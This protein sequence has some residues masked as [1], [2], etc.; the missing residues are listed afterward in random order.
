[1]QGQLVVWG[2]F[3]N[4]NECWNCVSFNRWC[5]LVRGACAGFAWQRKNRK[6]F[7]GQPAN[8]KQRSQGTKTATIKKIDTV[9]VLFDASVYRGVITVPQKQKLRRGTHHSFAVNL[10]MKSTSFF[11]R[12]THVSQDTNKR[13]PHLPSEI[14]RNPSS[15]RHERRALFQ[16][17]ARA[18]HDTRGYRSTGG[19]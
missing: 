16:H 1:M 5:A 3:A 14:F 6:I 18:A 17:P 15:S 4:S 19:R 11:R 2:S 12:F 10:S 9:S 13:G 8:F 7:I